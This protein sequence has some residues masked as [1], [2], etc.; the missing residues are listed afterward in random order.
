VEEKQEAHVQKG[1]GKGTKIPLE[2]K[3]EN[4]VKDFEKPVERKEETFVQRKKGKRK[5]TKKPDE[6]DKTLP[7]QVEEKSEKK[8]I[9][10]V[11]NIA[12]LDNK[13]FKRLIRKCRESRKEVSQLKK[14]SMYDQAYGWM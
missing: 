2:I 9:E 13:T 14:E 3:D 8:P 4:S 1:K 12:P 10:T 7:M 5:A 11:H 6:V